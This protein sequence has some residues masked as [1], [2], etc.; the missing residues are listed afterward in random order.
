MWNMSSDSR[1]TVTSNKRI[2]PGIDAVL[3]FP[4]AQNNEELEENI[5]NFDVMD[6]RKKV[7]KFAEDVELIFDGRASSRVA[8]EIDKL[9]QNNRHKEKRI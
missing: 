9:M 4:I 8:D 5:L 6:Y 7:E 1:K 3:P 2:I